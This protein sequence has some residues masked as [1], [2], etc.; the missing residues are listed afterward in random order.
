MLTLLFTCLLRLFYLIY[1]DEFI[2]ITYLSLRGGSTSYN[3][4]VVLTYKVFM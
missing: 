2:V 1:E 4:G 3:I